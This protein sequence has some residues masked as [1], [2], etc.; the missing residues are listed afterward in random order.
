M[1]VVSHNRGGAY[2]ICDLDGTLA[3]APIVA[4]RVVPYFACEHLEL[5]DLE[6]HIDVS[7]ARLRELED[8]TV[9][10][11]DYPKIAEEPDFDEDDSVERT[12]DDDTENLSD[13]E[14]PLRLSVS[15]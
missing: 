10:D 14:E 6:Q 11:P 5:P 15:Q 13:D 7:A 12:P 9:S 1:L 3:H 8:T 2:I 4:F